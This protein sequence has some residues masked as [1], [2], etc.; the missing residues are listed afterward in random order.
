MNIN[1]EIKGIKE[2]Q[3]ILRRLPIVL[4]GNLEKELIS[5]AKEA[6]TIAKESLTRRPRGMGRVDTGRLRASVHVSSYSKNKHQYTAKKGKKRSFTGT[7][8][9]RPKHPLEVFIGTNVDY[10][11]KISKILPYLKPAARI[12]QR[13]L[14]KRFIKILTE[15]K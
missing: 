1:V 14:R 3:A 11:D 10:A 12:A 4:S 9:E 2:T 15:I 8:K 13:R 6:E 5:T 7:L